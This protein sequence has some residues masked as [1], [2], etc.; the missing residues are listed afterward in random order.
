MYD[1]RKS[2]AIDLAE[3]CSLAR[4]PCGA[5]LEPGESLA[6]PEGPVAGQTVGAL[7]DR[8]L[9]AHPGYEAAMRGGVLSVRR[10]GGACAAALERPT[11][12][13]R[14]PIRPAR[15]AALMVLRASGWPGPANRGLASLNGDREDA[16]YQDVDVFVHKGATVRDA[17]DAIALGDGRMLWIAEAGPK[18]C[19]A[20][21]FSNW[22]KPQP[23]QGSSVMVSVSGKNP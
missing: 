18:T 15:V 21:R 1:E 8:L 22:R 16:R 14:Y 2:A 10:K 11:P 20:F 4:L 9:A 3:L 19:S 12:A 5:V 23:L 13:I 7:L 17:L 6:A